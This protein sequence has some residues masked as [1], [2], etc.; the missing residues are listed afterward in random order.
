VEPLRGPLQPPPD[1][2]AQLRWPGLAPARS[3]PPDVAGPLPR[4]LPRHAG[5]KSER[6]QW[7]R[8]W[9]QRLWKSSVDK[10]CLQLGRG[11]ARLSG[12]DLGRR[13]WLAGVGGGGGCCLGAWL[14]G[15]GGGAGSATTSGSCV[16]SGLRR[17]SRTGPPANTAGCHTV[18][19]RLPQ[20]IR[21]NPCRG[22]WL[23]RQRTLRRV[24]SRRSQ[25]GRL[26]CV[27][28]R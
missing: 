13:A 17:C 27:G 16:A 15:V 8:R 25:C 3:G 14:A 18:Q 11:F 24:E 12:V 28:A 6:Q 9:S 20:R 1:S 5:L 19:R 7:W 23:L 4:W 26:W 10:L 21:S 2:P 22:S